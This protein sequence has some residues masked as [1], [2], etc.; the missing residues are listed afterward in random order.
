MVILFEQDN[1]SLGVILLETLN[2][3]PVCAAP[4]IDRLV[5]VANHEYVPVTRGQM[6]DQCVLR[7][8]GILELVYQDMH[9]A[10]GILLA[11]LGLIFQQAGG[12]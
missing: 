6:L 3:A 10:L 9:E 1:L 11:H 12:P 5:R 4:A 8:V 2:V 7:Q